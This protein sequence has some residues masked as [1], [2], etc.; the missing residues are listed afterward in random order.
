MGSIL[1]LRAD[2]KNRYLK[3]AKSSKKTKSCIAECERPAANKKLLALSLLLA[4][5][6][7]V[8]ES[9]FLGR[10]HLLVRVSLAIEFE[11]VIGVCEVLLRFFFGFPVGF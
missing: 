2:S 9:R 1:A 7:K 10:G 8:R 11:R 6:I 3:L 5:L 4:G